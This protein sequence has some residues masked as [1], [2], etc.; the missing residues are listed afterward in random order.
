MMVK[1]CHANKYT[2]YRLD[3][4]ARTCILYAFMQSRQLSMRQHVSQT[5]Q[6]ST[7]GE[8]HYTIVFHTVIAFLKTR[9]VIKLFHMIT[10]LLKL[11]ADVSTVRM[12]NLHVVAYSSLLSVRMYSCARALRGGLR[13]HYKTV[14]YQR[15][16]SKGTQVGLS[17]YQVRLDDIAWQWANTSIMPI[18]ICRELDCHIWTWCLL[19]DHHGLDYTG[20]TKPYLT[21]L[22][23]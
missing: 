16:Y 15:A 1:E 14:V 7:T 9:Q 6:T 23:E 4:A 10:S 22:L 17:R 20:I 2:G 21:I 8:F 13:H 12:L 11:V 5:K 19:Q 18:K 3:L